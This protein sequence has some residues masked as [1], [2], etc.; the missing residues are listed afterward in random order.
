MQYCYNYHG[1]VTSG[2][3]KGLRDSLPAAQ[4]DSLLFFNLNE[5]TKAEDFQSCT[6]ERQFLYPEVA[7]CCHICTLPA[8]PNGSRIPLVPAPQN[9]PR[10]GAF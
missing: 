3:A 8:T 10:Q 7:Y 9:L 2:E 6:E 1:D 5:V 4:N